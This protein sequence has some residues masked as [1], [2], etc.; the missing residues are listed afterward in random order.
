MFWVARFGASQPR[1]DSRSF[2][3]GFELSNLPKA[4]LSEDGKFTSARAER[5]AA[6]TSGEVPQQ[7]LPGAFRNEANEQGAA[8]VPIK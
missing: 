4:I 2:S 3:I 8:R 1:L 5:A 6:S 7:R